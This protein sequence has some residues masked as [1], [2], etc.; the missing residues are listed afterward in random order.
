VTVGTRIASAI[1]LGVAK[2]APNYFAGVLNWPTTSMQDTLN[3][4]ISDGQK[5]WWQYENRLLNFWMNK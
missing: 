4:F 3:D 5:T 2:A 1:D